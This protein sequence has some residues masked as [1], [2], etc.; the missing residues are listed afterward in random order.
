MGFKVY[1]SN[2]SKLAIN[3]KFDGLYIPAFNKKKIYHKINKKNFCV[4][5]SAHNHREIKEK[6]MQNA[7][8][9][10][11]SPLFTTKGKKQL[12]INKFKI[13]SKYINKKL[14]ALGGISEK[15]MKKLNILKVSGFASISYIMSKYDK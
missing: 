10:F 7:D 11:L 8:Y 2:N 1:L 12:G 15:N 5:G 14:I 9:I 4:L 13:L 6:L 3:L